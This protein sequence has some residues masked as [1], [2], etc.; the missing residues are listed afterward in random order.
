MK[1]FMLCA[2]ML[3]GLVFVSDANAFGGR[4]VV[5]SGGFIGGNRVIVNNG[6]RSNVIV[7]GGFGANVIV[8][9]PSFVVA[10]QVLVPSVT[11]VAPS[12]QVLTP[13]TSVIVNRGLFGG[14]SVIVH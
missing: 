9:Q 5:R 2:A 14:R 4:T 13:S 12:V 1:K 11:T 7:G 6:F 3:I 8:A 10:P